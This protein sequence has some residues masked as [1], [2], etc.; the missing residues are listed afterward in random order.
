MK[1]NLYNS[2]DE[3]YQHVISLLQNLPQ[4]KASENFEY[5]LRVKI[6]NNNFDLKTEKN[7]ASIGWWKFTVPAMATTAAV[8]L[9][10]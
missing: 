8:I 9:M 4:V 10:A 3:E 2:K 6:E 1:K 7:H 5:N